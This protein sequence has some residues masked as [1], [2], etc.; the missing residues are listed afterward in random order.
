MQK[1]FLTALSFILLFS[2]SPSYAFLDYLFGGSSS[3]DAIDNSAVGD[4][5]SWWTG[6]PAY[7]FNP[8]YSPQNALQAPKQGAQQ[9]AAPDPTVNYVPQQG[10]PVTQYYPPTQYQQPQGPAN[11]PPQYAPQQ[12]VAQYQPPQP[13]YPAGVQYQQA[14]PQYAP[15]QQYQGGGQYQNVPQ[16]Q[17][18]YPVQ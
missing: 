17:G 12:P 3:R 4:L 10:A 6:N 5:R 8:Y 15:P 9:Q 7:V 14:P 1:L 13:Q 2:A 11:Y 18:G 16:T